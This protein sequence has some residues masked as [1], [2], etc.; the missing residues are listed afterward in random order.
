MSEDAS[1]GINQDD[2]EDEDEGRHDDAVPEL[3]AGESLDFC[4]SRFYDGGKQ[5]T[6]DVPELIAEWNNESDEDYLMGPLWS[7]DDTDDV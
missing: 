3:E 4:L 7:D 1:I 2:C 5:F 6:D